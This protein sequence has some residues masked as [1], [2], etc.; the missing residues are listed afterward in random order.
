MSK[1]IINKETCIGCGLCAEDC[2]RNAILSIKDKAE[3]DLSLCNECGHCLAVYPM[4]SVSM[5]L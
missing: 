4:H 5:P 2:S 3:V 1:V